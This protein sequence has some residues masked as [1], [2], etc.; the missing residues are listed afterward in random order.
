M[1]TMKKMKITAKNQQKIENCAQ[2]LQKMDENPKFSAGVGEMFLWDMIPNL[3][4][5]YYAFH[6][7]LS[8][9]YSISNVLIEGKNYVKGKKEI[10][11]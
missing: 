4:N 9:M 3:L 2:K 10:G 8:L 11:K 6:D 1:K 5:S 7:Q